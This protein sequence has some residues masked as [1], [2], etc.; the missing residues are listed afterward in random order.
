MEINRVAISGKTALQRN[1]SS[2]IVSIVGFVV[3]LAAIGVCLPFFLMNP[4]VWAWLIGV[5]FGS[6]TLVLSFILLIQ[7]L[8]YVGKCRQIDSQVETEFFDDHLVIRS[9]VN[10]KKTLESKVAYRQIGFFK[11]SKEALCLIMTVNI[12]IVVIYSPGITIAFIIEFFIDNRQNNLREK[13]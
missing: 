12:A 11:V 13:V 5:G 7:I 3:G 1:R 2:L 9:F 6:F 8:A 10:G 4:D